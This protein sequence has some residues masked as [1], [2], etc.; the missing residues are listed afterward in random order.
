MDSKVVLSKFADLVALLYHEGRNV[1]HLVK[2][3]SAIDPKFLSLRDKLPTN[4]CKA[5]N[6]IRPLRLESSQ[7]R[8]H[9][10][11][12]C[13]FERHFKLTLDDLADLYSYPGWKGTLYCGNA[14]LPIA[15]KVMEVSHLLDCGK[16]EEAN[17]LVRLISE[18]DHNTGKVSAKLKNLDSC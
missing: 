15:H 10:E 16:E 1:R 18:M 17:C 12:E 5:W 14:W 9:K 7:A 3:D 13:T 6:E 8:S 2:K 4:R 11:I